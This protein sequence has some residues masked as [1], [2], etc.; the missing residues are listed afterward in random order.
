MH[1]GALD[2]D[3]LFVRLVLHFDVVPAGHDDED[4]IGTYRLNAVASREDPVL[5][6]DATTAEVLEGR[7]VA[8][9]QRDLVREFGF[10]GVG[11]TDHATAQERYSDSQSGSERRYSD[12]CLRCY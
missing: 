1:V 6:E 11:T 2:L 3:E 5:V 10:F 9:L 12:G 7:V 4:A 8:P